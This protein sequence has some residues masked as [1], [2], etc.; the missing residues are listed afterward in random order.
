M[1][2]TVADDIAVLKDFSDQKD[3]ILLPEHK[4]NIFS[5]SILS[6]IRKEVF[7]LVYFSGIA[8]GI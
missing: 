1:L 3:L 2:Y 5:V 8:L 6:E 7:M 4:S